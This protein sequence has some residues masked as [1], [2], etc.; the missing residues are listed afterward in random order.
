MLVLFLLILFVY[1]CGRAL[2][3]DVGRDCNRSLVLPGT[4]L[5]AL[6]VRRER[7]RR[8]VLTSDKRGR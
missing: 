5:I 7:R 6:L 1:L 4:V 3:C 2:R 8:E